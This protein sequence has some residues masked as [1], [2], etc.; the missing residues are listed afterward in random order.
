MN[1]PPDEAKP[2]TIWGSNRLLY[3]DHVSLS[4]SSSTSRSHNHR[5]RNQRGMSKLRM[6]ATDY[7][8]DLKPTSEYYGNTREAIEAFVYLESK[9]STAAVKASAHNITANANDRGS[10]AGQAFNDDSNNHMLDHGYAP[11]LNFFDSYARLSKEERR[12]EQRRRQLIAHYLYQ[13]E[14]TRSEEERLMEPSLHVQSLIQ[15]PSSSAVK[16]TPRTQV[17]N[18]TVEDDDDHRK[19]GGLFLDD[20][21]NAQSPNRSCLRPAGRVGFLRRRARD[22]ACIN[23]VGNNHDS[24][25]D[26]N[27][28]PYDCEDYFKTGDNAT[29]R[30]SVS[31]NDA[32]VITPT[33]PYAPIS[34]S[35]SPIH[36]LGNHSKSGTKKQE[37][38]RQ[39][40]PSCSNSTASTC[41]GQ[42]SSDSTPTDPLDKACH[43]A[44][45]PPGNFYCF[46]DHQ[47]PDDELEEQE[48]D[49]KFYCSGCESPTTTCSHHT[50]EYGDWICQ[51]SNAQELAV[52]TS[53]KDENGQKQERHQEPW[54]EL[55]VL[56]P[57]ALYRIWERACHEE[58]KYNRGKP[59]NEFQ[60]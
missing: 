6:S 34:N 2:S 43:A 39:S 40:V 8:A 50:D 56:P 25:K 38:P 53:N 17:E 35:Q 21:D 57:E 60:F 14:Q 19:V 28:N 55:L 5:E 54:R 18:S 26:L 47:D 45:D 23:P 13:E 7:F 51:V 22:L 46:A 32:S 24:F 3:K 16:V 37:L 12:R 27:D 10:P 42:L 15:P 1:A 52:S 20:D 59:Q 30:H 4:S 11:L 49:L 44:L 29:R 41:S 9:R 58:R 36:S 48:L 31:T 33:L